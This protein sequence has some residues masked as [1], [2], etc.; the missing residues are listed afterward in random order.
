[1]S[2]PPPVPPKAQGAS[3]SSTCPLCLKCATPVWDPHLK[4]DVNALERVQCSAACFVTNNYKCTSS[5]TAMLKSLS[6]DNLHRRRD[7][8]LALMYK[9]RLLSPPTTY[10][11]RLTQELEPTINTTSAISL[12]PQPL[13]NIRF[14]PKLS[15]NGTAFLLRL[16]RL[17]LQG[18]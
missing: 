15:H 6:W 5:V 4:K 10:L 18:R 7:V 9:I 17:H 1:M 12:P 13:T 2:Q 16:W 3:Q 8:R 14:S 11:L